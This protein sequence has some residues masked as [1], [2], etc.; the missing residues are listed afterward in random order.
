M[1]EATLTHG[2]EEWGARCIGVQQLWLSPIGPDWR[3]LSNSIIMTKR[4]ESPEGWM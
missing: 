2:A 4:E 3:G 1:S